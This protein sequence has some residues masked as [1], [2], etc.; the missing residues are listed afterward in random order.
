MGNTTRNAIKTDR[1]L[2]P[3][4]ISARMT[5]EA[6]GTDLTRTMTGSSKSFKN[7]K[8][9]AA[10][11]VRMPARNAPKNPVLILPKVRPIVLQNSAVEICAISAPATSAG[12]TR[13]MEL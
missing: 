11:P 7:G 4:Q 2:E 12:P 1:F 5:K 13:M 10:L 6:T 8:R 3:I 9:Q